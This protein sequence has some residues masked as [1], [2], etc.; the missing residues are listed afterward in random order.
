MHILT[1]KLDSYTA[2][3]DN[4]YRKPWYAKQK[5]LGYKNGEL[6]DFNSRATCNQNPWYQAQAK[7]KLAIALSRVQ[8]IVTY[9]NFNF[10][11]LEKAV[12]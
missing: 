5:H 1:S 4:F 9:V 8:R 10:K 7:N 3:I 6:S 2:L 12:N 11:L